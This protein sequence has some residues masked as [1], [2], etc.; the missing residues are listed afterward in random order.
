MGGACGPAWEGVGSSFFFFLSQKS[1]RSTAG[2]PLP[3]F[4]LCANLAF[5]HREKGLC[6]SLRQAQQWSELALVG[7]VRLSLKSEIP[8][9]VGDRLYPE[10]C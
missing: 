9:R 2:I 10:F 6:A 4:V 8:P 5:L 7:A 3:G 1:S